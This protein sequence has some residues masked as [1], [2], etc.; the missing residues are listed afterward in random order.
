MVVLD[1]SEGVFQPKWFYDSSM[2]ELEHLKFRSKLSSTMSV[3]PSA[4]GRT[5]S[6]GC[7]AVAISEG[8]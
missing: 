2:R 6:E 5:D 7:K 4:K 3:C 8:H 1:D